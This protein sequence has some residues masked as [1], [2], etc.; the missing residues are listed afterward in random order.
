MSLLAGKAM[1]IAKAKRT[2]S[3]KPRIAGTAQKVK[4]FISKYCTHTKGE[5]AGQPFKLLPWQINVIDRLFGTVDDKGLRQYR[6]CYVVIPKKNGKSELGAAVALYMLLHDDDGGE[7][8]SAAADTMQASITFNIAAQMVR[9]NDKLYEAITINETLKRMSYSKKASIYQVLSAEHAT[10]HGLNPSCIIFDEVHAQPDDRLWNVLTSGTHYA[11]RQ[12]L[13]FAMTTAGIWDTNSLW[14]RL[15]DRS[16][17]ILDGRIEDKTFLPVLYIA[18]KDKDDPADEKVWKKTNPSLGRIFT[19]AKIREEFNAAKDSPVDYNNFLRFRLNI[20]TQSL[21]AWIRAEHWDKCAFPVE[22]EMLKGR[23]CCAGLDL[24]RSTDITAFVLVF[25][26]VLPS[27]KYAVICRFFIPADNLWERVRRDK[28]PYDI[29]LQQ[30]YLMTTP[31]NVIDYDFVLG[32]IK[33]DSRKF[34]IREIVFDRWGSPKIA[35]D[36]QELGFEVPKNDK[37]HPVRCLTEFGQGF[38]SMNA[39]TKELEKMIL[40]GEIAH[41]GNP[42]LKWMAGNVV[43]KSDPAG[44]VKPDKNASPDKIDGIVALI[45]AIGRVA[46]KRPEQL[47]GIRIM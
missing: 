5:W 3:K 4:N 43:L 44:N 22:E 32:Q 12:Q 9:N 33:S 40:S 30:G 35:N 46:Q 7:V 34:N 15:L 42:V 13:V 20:P 8:Y 23:E 39:P 45:M 11:R 19:L 29:W 36:L 1:I 2:S 16:Q 6:F 25:P 14:W 47:P 18:D 10:K 21:S 24:S 26:P 37:D 38:A 17:K 41:G 31:G 28:V 27:E